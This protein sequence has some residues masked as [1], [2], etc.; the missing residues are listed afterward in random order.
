M[1]TLNSKWL[2]IVLVLVG[3]LTV[4][5]VGNYLYHYFHDEPVT[6]MTQ[7][8]AETSIGVEKAAENA[9]VKLDSSQSKQVAR[10]IQVIRETQQVPI[11]TVYTT[12]E[13]AQEKSE[14]AVKDNK[15][16]FAIVTDPNNTDKEVSL[17][18]IPDDTK[19]ELNQY[20]IQAYRKVIRQITYSKSSISDE[21]IVG[22]S[23][24]RKITN[25]G[26][27]I[28]IGVDY[29]IDNKKPYVKLSYMW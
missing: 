24:N 7:H 8:E 9:G 25:D 6:T 12:G 10:E 18:D 2:K 17:K 13:K 16:D 3:V 1:I 21:G 20:N 4:A 22:F 29:N 23:I 26:Q 14:Q 15:A 27:Y 28:G 19:V 5:L 11:Y